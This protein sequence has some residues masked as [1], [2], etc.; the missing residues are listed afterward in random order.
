M[1]PLKTAKSHYATLQ[2]PMQLAP[3]RSM[4]SVSPPT[5][6]LRTANAKRKTGTHVT[7]R[8]GTYTLAQLDSEIARLESLLRSYE[9]ASSLVDK[10]KD[11]K[12]QYPVAG[13]YLCR[14]ALRTVKPKSKPL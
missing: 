1:S 5:S 4:G 3:A 14:R 12:P 6:G 2:S 9:L 13:A 7:A 8:N 11:G 10:D